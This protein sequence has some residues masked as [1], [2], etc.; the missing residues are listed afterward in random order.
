MLAPERRF[1]HFLA[2]KL[3]RT[4]GELLASISSSELIDWA[5]HFEL[6]EQERA[7]NKPARPKDPNTD[8]R[9]PRMGRHKV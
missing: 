9:L 8:P 6:L 1:Y 3:G 2:E 7:V 4:V 5:A